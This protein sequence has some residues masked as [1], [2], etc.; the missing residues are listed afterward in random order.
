[1]FKWSLYTVAGH[2]YAHTWELKESKSMHVEIILTKKYYLL[3]KKHQ[4]LH[5]SQI[6]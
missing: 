2:L 6:I 1:M 3:K 5:R 4:E